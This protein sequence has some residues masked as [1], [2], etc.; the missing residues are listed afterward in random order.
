METVVS[1]FGVQPLRIGG[2]EIYTRELS[3]QL[4]ERGWR[5]VAVFSG[6]ATPAV[7]EYLA[8]LPNLTL[9]SIPAIEDSAV[10]GAKAVWKALSRHRPKI[11]HFQFTSLIGPY[12][13]LGKLAGAEKVFFTAQG[14]SPTGFV[15]RR[16]PLWKRL[17]ARVVN[18]PLTGVFCI[19][20][21]VRQ[22]LRTQDM[23]PA[24]R[25]HRLYN[26]IYIPELA[27]SV[28]QGLAFRRRFGIPIDKE[29]VVQVSWVIPEKGVPDLLEAARLVLAKRPN[30][31]FA[32]AGNGNYTGEYQRAAAHMGIGGSVTW[33]GLLENPMRD[34]VYAAADVFCL[35]SRWEEAFGWVIAEAMSFE[36]PVVA[37][38]VGGIP[39]VVADGVT[40]LLGPRSKPEVAAGHM[41]QLLGDAELRR[42]MGVAGRKRVEE[43]FELRRGVQE[44]V[45][46]YGI[47]CMPRPLV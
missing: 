43:M 42:R 41:L 46:H 22:I 39:E 8:D 21:N 34:G 28:E 33:C 38:A 37:T 27:G 15:A 14:S 7:R 40:G 1:L 45:R 18:A 44:V 5:H 29:L 26:A 36:R 2:A 32:I 30:T 11:L 35:L 9:E 10:N 20:D 6:P 47:S 19:S 16:A 3:L 17:A 24:E 4:A 31:H 23:V 13:W 12:S 25:L